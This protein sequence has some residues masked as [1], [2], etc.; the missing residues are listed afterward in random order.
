M[1]LLIWD[2]YFIRTFTAATKTTLTIY[3][4]LTTLCLSNVRIVINTNVG[5]CDNRDR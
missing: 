5:V 1:L 2:Y 4:N 3:P